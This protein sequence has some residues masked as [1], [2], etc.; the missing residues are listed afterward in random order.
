MPNAMIVPGVT[1]ASRTR[2]PGLMEDFLWL[3]A[4]LTDEEAARIA[5]VSVPTLCRWRRS[6]ARKLREQIRTRL[7][8]FV[9]ERERADKESLHA[10]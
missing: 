2:G 1:A 7:L 6:G 8:E 5:G 4:D 3:T 10:A 9:E